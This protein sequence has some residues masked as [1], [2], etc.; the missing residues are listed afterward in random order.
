MLNDASISYED[1]FRTVRDAQIVSL[2][3]SDM[4]EH[5]AMAVLEIGLSMLAPAFQ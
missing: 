2:Q 4:N 3:H 1:P 5:E